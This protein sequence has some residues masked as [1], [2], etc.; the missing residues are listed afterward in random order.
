MNMT[1]PINPDR[2]PTGRFA[3]GNRL[4]GNKAGSR[5]RVTRAIDA[6]LEGQHEALTAAAIS[7]ALAGDTVALRLCLDRL[8]PPRRDSPVSIALP[9]VRTASDAVK[10]SAALLAALVAGEV[11]PDEAGRIMAL[12]SAH[13]ALI[14]T[15][16]LEQR[17]AALEG[18][19][20]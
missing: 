18:D 15:C 14:E 13:K 6:L 8:A 1:A 2:I 5:H 10:A 7:K 17:I 12:L 9:A 20:K 11:T 16:D 19:M 3:K 4:A